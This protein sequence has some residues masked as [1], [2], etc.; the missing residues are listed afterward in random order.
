MVLLNFI[1]LYNNLSHVDKKYEPPLKNEKI[2]IIGVGRLI[3][4][5]NRLDALNETQ[6]YPG[7][8]IFE[9]QGTFSAHTLALLC[10][11]FDKQNY[12]KALFQVEHFTKCAG[13]ENIVSYVEHKLGAQQAAA[14]PTPTVC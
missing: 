11:H 6:K 13:L 10:Y 1:Y 14:P 2:K 9:K 8:F 3:V 5:M 12:P 4:K 7:L